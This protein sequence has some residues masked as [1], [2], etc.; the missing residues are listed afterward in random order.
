M[1]RAVPPIV[2]GLALLVLLLWAPAA[3]A[4]AT[5][6]CGRIDYEYPGGFGGASAIK[7]RAVHIGCRKA[8]RIVR[9]CIHGVLTD[10]WKQRTVPDRSVY[11]SHELLTSGRR[12][13]SYFAAGGGGC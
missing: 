5:H 4:Q 11:R 12:R 6:R 7:I 8:R 9:R 3:L 13:I 2:L 1:K 10:G